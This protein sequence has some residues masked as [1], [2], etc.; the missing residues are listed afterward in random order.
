MSLI[1]HTFFPSS[2]FDVNP[3][4]YQPSSS[5]FNQMS[6]FLSSSSSM[7][8]M[9]DFFD[10]FEDLDRMMSPTMQWINQP[11][12][13]LPPIESLL[14]SAPRR[15]RISI[16]C[17]GFQPDSI[18]TNINESN[19]Q[20]C[21]VVTGNEESGVVGSR[22]YS[23]KEFK[24]TYVLPKNAQ[25]EK[26]VSYM[27]PG[28][29]LIVDV[30]LA[31]QESGSGALESFLPKIVDTPEGGKGVELQLQLP[32]NVDP[33]KVQVNIR[34]RDLIVRVEDKN[35]TPDTYSR[36]HIYHKTRL[37]DNTDLNELRCTQENNQLRICAPINT[38]ITGSSASRNKRIPVQ[39]SSSNPSIQ[40][41]QRNN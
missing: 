19:G 20:Q 2:M 11:V 41:Q 29:Q 16:D 22:D 33:N 13:L 27:T 21:L 17:N 23:K 34:G 24:R 35:E 9:L 3:W 14:P 32:A 8:S 37:P 15:H 6:P 18:K 4:G 10:P 40:Q 39:G 28:G 1:P 30:P 7:P 5:L 31:V 38:A 12:G 25:H 26:L 36:V